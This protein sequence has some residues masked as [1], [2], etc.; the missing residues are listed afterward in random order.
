MK[1]LLVV[2]SSDCAKNGHVDPDFTSLVYGDSNGNGKIILNNLQAGS[3]VFFHT[4][5]GGEK[6][7]TAYFYVE[8]ILDKVNNKF[9]I[10]GLKSDAKSDDVIIMGSRVH[11]KI[12]TIPLK[13]DRALLLELESFNLDESYFNEK[14]N[15]GYSELEA[16][17]HKTFNFKLL[18]EKDKENLFEKCLNRG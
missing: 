4:N 2:Y 18:S 16:I 11:S 8:K 12:L 5:I 14:I 3:Y 13:L 15:N 10:E 9:E 17:S 7:I 6:Y 1:H